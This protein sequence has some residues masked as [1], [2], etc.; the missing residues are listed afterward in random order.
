MTAV[1]AV[2]LVLVA[3]AGT[4]LALT[5]EPL[6]QAIVAGIF[7]LMLGILFFVLQAP[8]VALSQIVVGGVALPAMILLA[9]A[10]VRA[11]EH[12]GRRMSRHGALRVFA[13]PAAGLARCCCGRS[14]ACR[15]SAT[16]RRL[17]RHRSRG[18]PIPAR[19]TTNAVSAITLRLPR[20]RHARSRSSS[21]SRPRSASAA[22]LRHQ[23]GER[24]A[25]PRR[26]RRSRRTR[27]RAALRVVGPALVG[28]TRARRRCT[29]DRAR[30]STPGGGFQGGVVLAARSSAGLPSDALRDAAGGSG[31]RAARSRSPRRSAPRGFVLLGLGGP[32][33]R[34][35]RSWHNFLPA[36]GRRGDL[37]SAARSR[38]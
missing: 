3:V 18:S 20:V 16:T 19:A 5:R 11:R 34:A 7:G 4:L 9:L 33:V 23:R 17:R 21:C 26:R 35:A 22:L 12:R 14:P 2:L 8:D 15:T 28:P 24:D 6:R 1:Q 13:A 27:E 25:R 29:S 32:G 31:R 10:K 30:A 36:T 38:C 37:L